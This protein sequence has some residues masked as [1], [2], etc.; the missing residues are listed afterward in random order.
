MNYLILKNIIEATLGNFACK[1]CGGKVSES[2]I[3]ILGASSSGVNMEVTCPQCQAT[4]VI[5]AEMNVINGPEAAKVAIDNIK[6]YIA[7]QK[8]AP[9]GAAVSAGNAQILDQDVLALRE[10]LKHSSNVSDIF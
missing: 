7:S 1:N 3:Q 4:G 10:K 5:K 2:D 9:R 8:N 6:N